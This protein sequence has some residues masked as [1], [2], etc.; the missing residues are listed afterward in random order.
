MLPV[1]GRPP[2]RHRGTDDHTQDTVNT[3][4]HMAAAHMVHR[5]A[6]DK[7]PVYSQVQVSQTLSRAVFLQKQDDML[8]TE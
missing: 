6:A 7:R 5:M 3:A 4:R 2:H 1:Q 8:L